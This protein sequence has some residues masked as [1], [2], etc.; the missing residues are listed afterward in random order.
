LGTVSNVLNR[1][2]LVATETRRRVEE[3]IA[4]VGFVR[5]SAARQLRGARSPTIGLVVLDVD[6]PFF[7]AVARGVEDAAS[8][9]DHLLILCN[10]ASSRTREDR[11]LRMLEEQ[12]VAGILMTPV[13]KNPSKRVREIR[14]NGTPVVLLDRAAKGGQCSVAVDDVYGGRLAAEHLAER[15]HRRVAL[16]NGPRS[17]LQC[18]ERRIGFLRGLSERGLSLAPEDDVEMAEMTIGAGEEAAERLLGRR[19][20]P[21]A[22]FCTNDLLAI[23]VEHATLG[24]GRDV[25][26]DLAIIGYDDVDFAAMSFVPLTSVRQPT[27][28]L[29]YRA[30]KLLLDEAMGRAHRHEQVVFQPEL[31]ERAS[32]AAPTNG[33]AALHRTAA[34]PS[35]VKSSH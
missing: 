7:T 19:R 33:S 26:D 5:N 24:R 9:A 30:A 31:V 32:T 17:I 14:E 28:E 18:A 35:R 6:N 8:E 1:P 11:H 20:P 27:Y 3:A 12:R 2:E 23:G 29:G 15:G 34:R 25:P 16:V 22:V 13:G 4:A 10:S 21:T